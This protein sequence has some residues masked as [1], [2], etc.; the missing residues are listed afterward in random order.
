LGRPQPLDVPDPTTF[1]AAVS[2]AR[3]SRLG[4]NPDSDI[5]SDEAK[6]VD[7]QNTA[8]AYRREVFHR[9]GLFD[10]RFDACEDVEFNHR[11]F[12]AKL[13]CYFTPAVKIVYHPRTSLGG[14]FKQLARYGCGRARLAK[15]HAASLTLPALVP[16]LWLAWLVVGAAAS[17]L[18]PPVGWVYLASVALYL[19]VVLLASAWLGR[20][21]PLAV[22][23]RLPAVFFG[24]HAGFGWGFLREAIKGWK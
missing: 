5:Y 7:P 21:K 20:G 2:V 3:S 11:V 14:L 1:Q 10:E 6:F 18:L 8:V 4:H 22:R 9:V 16:P 23:L 12:E 17:L 24:I 13:T 19:G 15:K